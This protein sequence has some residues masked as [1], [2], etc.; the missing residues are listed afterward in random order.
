MKEENG[1]KKKKKKKGKYTVMFPQFIIPSS[2]SLLLWNF[3]SWVCLPWWP[4]ANSSYS[5]LPNH[6]K[7]LYTFST[8]TTPLLPR[9]LLVNLP[10]AEL[11]KFQIGVPGSIL[12]APRV[13]FWAAISSSS[14]VPRNS[15]FFFPIP[16]TMHWLILHC[17][18]VANIEEVTYFS[19]FSVLS[20]RTLRC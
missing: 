12:I 1:I 4:S 5:C 8:H 20:W 9:F 14:V 17:H 11:T 15:I 2:K 16:V 6:Y 13:G 3:Q 19:Y 18:L 10:K 7:S